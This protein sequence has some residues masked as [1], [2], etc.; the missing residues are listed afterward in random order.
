MSTL[1]QRIKGIKMIWML[2]CLIISTFISHG[3]G[4]SNCKLPQG[5]GTRIW[6][7]N[8]AKARKY[9]INIHISF[10]IGN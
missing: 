10:S 9:F 8:E 4:K 5:P 3:V 7:G 2:G 6:Y 1:A